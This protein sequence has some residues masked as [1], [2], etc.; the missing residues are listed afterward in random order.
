M[1]GGQPHQLRMK[2]GIVHISRTEQM[3][4]KKTAQSTQQQNEPSFSD[5]ELTRSR[6]LLVQGDILNTQGT[7]EALENVFC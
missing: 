7:L 3:L 1:F 6:L 5:Y 2:R 4:R